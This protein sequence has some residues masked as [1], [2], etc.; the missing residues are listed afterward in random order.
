MIKTEVEFHSNGEPKYIG[1]VETGDVAEAIAASRLY[2]TQVC[3]SFDMKA[4]DEIKA[5]RVDR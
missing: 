4:I 5:R 2:L 3:M 1:V